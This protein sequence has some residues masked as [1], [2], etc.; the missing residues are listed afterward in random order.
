MDIEENLKMRKY[1]LDLDIMICII[2]A[3]LLLGL[4]IYAVNN[5]TQVIAQSIALPIQLIQ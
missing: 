1:S 5:V 4:F 2:V 3:F